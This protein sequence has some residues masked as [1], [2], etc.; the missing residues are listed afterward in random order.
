MGNVASAHNQ[1]DERN[2]TQV[3][4]KERKQNRQTHPFLIPGLEIAA[5]KKKKKKVEKK[6]RRRKMERK[7]AEE[8]FASGSA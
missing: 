7:E 8:Q 5:K 2:E 1:E 3:V 6:R 4:R